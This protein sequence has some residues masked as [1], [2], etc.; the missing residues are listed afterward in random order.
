[1]KNASDAIQDF[2]RLHPS[3]PRPV[4]FKSLT[5]VPIPEPLTEPDLHQT[6]S[7]T[8][9]KVETDTWADIRTQVAESEVHESKDD[10]SDDGWGAIPI[11]NWDTPL[12]EP[13]KPRKPSSPPPLTMKINL[14]PNAHSRNLPIPDM[15]AC[16]GHFADPTIALTTEEINLGTVRN[17][18]NDR[19]RNRD[20][21]L[22]HHFP[23][24]NVRND[25]LN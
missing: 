25:I 17:R 13:S 7:W 1:L 3:A 22:L 21:T 24:N 23:P 11:D 18:K 16:I 5:F 4:D 14:N 8:N 19:I 15:Q 9:G 2:H 12:P 10:K 20:H 6:T